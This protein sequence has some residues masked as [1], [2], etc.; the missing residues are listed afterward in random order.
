MQEQTRRIKLQSLVIQLENS[1]ARALYPFF[2][3]KYSD[4]NHRVK[5]T[6]SA[7]A[8]REYKFSSLCDL[9]LYWVCT[10]VETHLLFIPE[11]KSHPDGA[12]QNQLEY[13]QEIRL[14]RGADNLC[15]SW[16]CC[17][18]GQPRRVKKNAPEKA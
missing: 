4:V 6:A 17:C 7:P 8:V 5:V 15:S 1:A 14:H 13:N 11:R 16:L 10:P 3:M 18:C 2:S 12:V 9:Q